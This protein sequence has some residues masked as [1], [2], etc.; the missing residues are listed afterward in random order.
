MA[1]HFGIQLGDTFLHSIVEFSGQ[2]VEFGARERGAPAG[3]PVVEE[4]DI[5]VGHGS[6]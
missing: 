5:D 3:A 6:E 4:H 1:K 2:I